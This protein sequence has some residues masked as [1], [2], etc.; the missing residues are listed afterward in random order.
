M[1]VSIVVDHLEIILI[2]GLHDDQPIRANP[3]TPVIPEEELTQKT[4]ALAVATL[5]NFLFVQNHNGNCNYFKTRPGNKWSS[6]TKD[7]RPQ[8]TWLALAL[9]NE[10]CKGDLLEVEEESLTTVDL[11]AVTVTT[12]KNDG[13]RREK[14]VKELKDVPL[15]RL[16]AFRDGKTYSYI[17]V[18]RSVDKP[19]EIT[20]NVPYEPQ[21]EYAFYML[22][23]QSRDTNI[24]E[25]KVKI[26][27][28]KGD[29]FCS[30]SYHGQI[31]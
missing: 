6:H 9:R 8:T 17:A 23:G 4:L 30:T 3:K 27:E 21:S 7:L 20:L 15:T 24:K 2:T 11:P 28:S 22:T 19:Q 12:L 1:T 26:Q 10:Y 31:T 5:D 18:N 13:S 29:D 25:D 14:K 16:Y